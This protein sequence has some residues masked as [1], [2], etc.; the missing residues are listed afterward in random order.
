MEEHAIDVLSRCICI[1]EIGQ[2]SIDKGHFSKGSKVRD[3][4]D[5]MM[6]EELQHMRQHRNRETRVCHM[7]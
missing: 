5:V 2:T 3:V 4:L 6:R 7:Q 1:M